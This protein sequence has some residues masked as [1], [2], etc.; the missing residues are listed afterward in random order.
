MKMLSS[1]DQ[2][3]ELNQCIIIDCNQERIA[4]P[5]L[6]DPRIKA[7]TLWTILKDLVGKDLSKFS[8]PVIL[9][10]PTSNIQ[11]YSEIYQN[12]HLLQK[13]SQ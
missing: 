4:L 2:M 1:N 10:E 6:R 7:S 9:N 3:K 11:K 5:I 8:L 13:A 12:N